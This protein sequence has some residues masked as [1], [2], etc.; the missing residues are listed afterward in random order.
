MLFDTFTARTVITNVKTVNI[1]FNNIYSEN[2]LNLCCKILN[3]WKTEEVIL[4]IDAL[5]NSAT[6]K[7]I[8]H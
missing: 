7:K 2:L 1:S 3:S 8:E 4:S 5:H 6:I